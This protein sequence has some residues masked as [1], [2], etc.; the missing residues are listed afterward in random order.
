METDTTSGWS[1]DDSSTFL[2]LAD[3]A[4][5]GRRE[6]V[7][8]LLS[9]IPAK[10]ESEFRVVDVCCGDATLSEAILERFSTSQILG[11]DGS[12]T[13]RR[14]AEERLSRF[15][16]RFDIQPFDLD[17]MQWIDRIDTPR[18]VVSSL[19]IHHLDA[20]GK[21]SLF[22]RLATRLEKGGALLIAD[23]VAPASDVALESHRASWRRAAADQSQALTGSI[24]LY[25]R[26]TAEGWGYYDGI[27]SDPEEQPSTLFEQLKWLEEAGFRSADCF[28]LRAGF[29]IYGGY[30]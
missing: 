21:R 17:D 2:D 1:E 18:C 28:W 11:L 23:I 8:V 12:E 13:M 16:D 25:D 19:A 27:E 5:I 4:V 10:E 20:D 30:V 6:Q 7:E 15:G 22:R 9:L 14:Q 3:V 29:A 26:A 24:E